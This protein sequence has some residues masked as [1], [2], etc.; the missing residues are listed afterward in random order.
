M[1][2][3]EHFVDEL[4]KLVPATGWK[5]RLRAAALLIATV[6]AHLDYGVNSRELDVSGFRHD[7]IRDGQ[8]G[9][10]IRHMQTHAALM[11]LGPIGWIPSWGLHML[12]WLQSRKGRAESLTEMRDNKAGQQLGKLMIRAFKG[13]LP[14]GQLK[15]EMLRRIAE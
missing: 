8:S 13:Q 2:A 9:E 12:D 3:C 5:R 10:A 15:V 14:Q 4:V 11:L 6:K 7:L 1:N